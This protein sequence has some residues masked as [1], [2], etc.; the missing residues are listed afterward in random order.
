MQNGTVPDELKIARVAPLF[1]NGGNSDLGSYRLI[2]FDF[3]LKNP[4]K[5]HV[6]PL[7]LAFVW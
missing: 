6:Q 2:V 5:N 3:F 1:K 4:W 7:L